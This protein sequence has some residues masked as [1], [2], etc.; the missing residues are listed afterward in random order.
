MKDRLGKVVRLNPRAY[1]K[2]EKNEK[3][4]CTG[5]KHWLNAADYQL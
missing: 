2:K 1:F 5:W 3:S 4:N